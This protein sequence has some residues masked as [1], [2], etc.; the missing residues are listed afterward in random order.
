MEERLEPFTEEHLDACARVLVSAFGA[1]PWNENWT[2]VNAKKE[3]TR[4]LSLPWSIG[5][6]AVDGG[7]VLGFVEGWREQDGDREAFYLETL[8]VRP[9]AQGSGVGSRLLRHLKKKLEQARINTIYLIT[10]R[11]TPAESFYKKNG[12][13]ISDEDVVMIQEW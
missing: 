9:D 5:F 1:E 4:S 7:E 3:L 12:Y 8:C 13:R 6:V 2:F 10:H 11:G